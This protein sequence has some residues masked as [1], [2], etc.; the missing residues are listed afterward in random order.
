MIVPLAMLY[1]LFS[2]FLCLRNVYFCS[3]A[4]GPLKEITGGMGLDA[5]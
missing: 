3:N 4:K 2:D 5:V 1:C